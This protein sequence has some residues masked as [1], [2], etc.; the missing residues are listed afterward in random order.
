MYDVIV[1]GGGPAG[2]TAS[3]YSV[4][5]GFK[6]LLLQLGVPG[7]QAATTDRIDNYPGFVD[8]VSGPELM[9]NFHQQAERFGVE[10]KFQGVTSLELEGPVKKVH[11]GEDVYETKS[12]IIASG[13]H[14]RM[15][16]VSGEANLR[17]KGVSY[18]ATCDGF[19]FKDR[20]VLVIGGGDTALQEALFLS[21]FCKKVTIVHRRDELRGAKMLQDRVAKSSNIEIAW[22]SV[23]EEIIGENSVEGAVLK[24]VDTGELTKMDVAGIFIFVGYQPHVS[25]LPENLNYDKLDYLVTDDELQTN[26]PGVFAVGDIRQKALRQ[27]T[28]AVGDGAEVTVALERYLAEQ[29]D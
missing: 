17:G 12:V 26:I 24:N 14:P 25:F 18:C 11:A 19:F 7:G 22:S 5:S 28:T 21:K 1:I 3:M 27:V 23:L 8:G 16:G 6:T 4:R 2:L 10:F 20:E 9:M 29:E 15:L 13:A